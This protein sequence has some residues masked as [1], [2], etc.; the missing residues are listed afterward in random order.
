MQYLFS[1]ISQIILGTEEN[2]LTTYKPVTCVLCAYSTVPSKMTVGRK[3]TFFSFHND[4][5]RGDL[6]LTV[7]F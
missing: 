4:P 7:A 1:S 3:P 2:E 6:Y 5:Y